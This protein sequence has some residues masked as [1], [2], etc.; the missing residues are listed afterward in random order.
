MASPDT[1]RLGLRDPATVNAAGEPIDPLPAGV[2]FRDLPTHSD[3]RGTVCE[4]FDPRWTGIPR[5]WS[6]ST[7]SR[8]ARAG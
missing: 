6:S 5:R 3:G 1:T 4:I 7:C 2:T 8:S